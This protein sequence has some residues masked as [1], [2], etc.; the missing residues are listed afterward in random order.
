ML[1]G[2]K[3]ALVS[4]NMAHNNNMYVAEKKCL[5]KIDI[6]GLPVISHSYT[7]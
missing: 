7:R 1:D 3:F 5:G 2:M 4:I 6:N